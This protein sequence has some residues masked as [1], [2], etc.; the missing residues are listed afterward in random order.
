MTISSNQAWNTTHPP[1]QRNDEV[2]QTLER[3]AL[4]FDR[5]MALPPRQALLRNAL[6]ALW[7][8]C[9]DSEAIDLAL[10]NLTQL[11]PG[12]DE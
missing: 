8:P 11:S 4:L 10:R 3:R 2:T 5:I 12:S 7:Y 1:I 6:M 9:F